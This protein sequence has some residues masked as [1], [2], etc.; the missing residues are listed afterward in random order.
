MGEEPTLVRAKPDMGL[1]HRHIL[2][3]RLEPTMRRAAAAVAT[4]ILTTSVLVGSSPASAAPA[5]DPAVPV[6]AC[7]G[8]E[9]A[10]CEVVDELLGL[11]RDAGIDVDPLES[12][13]T[14]LQQLA[15]EQLAPEPAPEPER[16]PAPPG[17]SSGGTATSSSASGPT[18]FDGALSADGASSR[19]GAA[20]QSVPVVPVGGALELGP[21]ALPNFSFTSKPATSADEVAAEAAI[22]DLV[23]PAVA[24]ALVP[25]DPDSSRATAVIMALC[26]LMLASGLLLDQRRKARIPIRI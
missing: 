24:A 17:P 26:M 5:E 23:A 13:L 8:L 7:G 6:P 4:A 21:L 19:G 3:A 20:G 18:G 9:D 16:A 25:E 15:E 14:E 10:S 1:V 2:A 12:T 22:A 11:L